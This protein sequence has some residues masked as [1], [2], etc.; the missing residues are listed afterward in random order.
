M[1]MEYNERR[2]YMVKELN[3]IKGI[4][5][6]NPDGAF[7][8]FPNISKLYGTHFKEKII[9]N[10]TDVVNYILDEAHVAVVP[11]KAFEYPDHIRFTFAVSMESIKKGLSRIK[12]AIDKLK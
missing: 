7:Y 11:G 6:N 4:S 5:C 9:N 1:C 3:S 10:E 2:D 8:V 12:T